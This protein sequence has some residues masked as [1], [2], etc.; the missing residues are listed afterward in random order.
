MKFTILRYSEDPLSGMFLNRPEESIEF[1]STWFENTNP[2]ILNTRQFVPD[3][4]D[5][6]DFDTIVLFFLAEYSK[7]LILTNANILCEE[8]ILALEKYNKEKI[9]ETIEEDKIEVPF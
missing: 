6:E 2:S 7:T 1:D 3:T 9:I 4:E 5:S 8:A